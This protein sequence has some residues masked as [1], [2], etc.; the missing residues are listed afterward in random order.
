MSL[1]GQLVRR[2]S[3]IVVGWSWA[4]SALAMVAIGGARITRPV[5]WRDELCSISAARRS[6]PDLFAML[7]HVDAVSGFYY[8]LLHAW[9]ALFGD[10]LLAVRIP[11][12]LAM[13]GAA[14]F[15]AVTGRD[16][17]S[18][19]VGLAAGLVFAA[20]P[21][22]SRYAQEARGYALCVLG[23]AAA[24]WLLLRAARQPTWSRWLAYMLATTVA[25]LANAVALTL[26]AAHAAAVAGWWWL[27][28]DRRLA[29]FMIA[30]LGTVVTACPMLLAGWTQRD[31]QL[32]WLTPPGLPELR[33]LVPTLA[34]SVLVAGGL[35]TLGAL[36]AA[37]PRRA[38]LLGACGT[39][40]PIVAV[41][42]AAQI[43]PLWYP[44][45]L[46]FI[47]PALV[48]LATG[49]T[50]R[51]PVWATIA[52]VL[53]VA[54]IGEHDQRAIREPGSH[55]SGRYPYLSPQAP[56]RYD[57]LGNQLTARARPGDGRLFLPAEAH[58][59]YETYLSWRYG[60]HQPQLICRKRSAT[61]AQRL[62]PTAA[63]DFDRCIGS[64]DRLWV[65]RT[66]RHTIGPLDDLPERISRPLTRR[67][68]IASATYSG[69]FTLILTVKRTVP[70]TPTAAHR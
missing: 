45:Y 38:A 69:G 27:D 29:R 10:S 14:A 35:L 7:H 52:M 58:W 47:V 57:L 46:L 23:A 3:Q 9:I 44:R 20:L 1:S 16:L 30:A 6:L 26:L 61:Q 11:S 13:G 31:G 8:L 2:T 49:A 62:L 54:V 64:T 32:F 53:A 56:I 67:Y 66:G 60:T 50:T 21:A 33:E 40:I 34:G 18:P 43:H 4:W 25:V 48:V 19:R 22:T 51:L 63:S 28:R 37:G 41:F 65:L 15:V 36:G 5:I 68:R 17:Y 24:G 39:L 70:N 42:S 55:T 12:L 59:Q